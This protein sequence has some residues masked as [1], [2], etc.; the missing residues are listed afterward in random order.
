[1]TK[2]EFRKRIGIRNRPGHGDPSL[3]ANVYTDVPALGLHDEVAKLPWLG[4]VAGD[5]QAAHKTAQ[6]TDFRAVSA[7]RTQLSQVAIGQ[8]KADPFG[9]AQ[10]VEVAGIE[11]ACP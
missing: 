11:P 8:Q 6:N 7:K 1:M 5:A 3:T 4:G 2:N 9:P 10:V